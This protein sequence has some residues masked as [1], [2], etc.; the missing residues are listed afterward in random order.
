MNIE[1]HNNVHDFKKVYKE[2]VA[3]LV[4]IRNQAGITQQFMAEW[5]KVD[6]RKIISFENCKKIELE[7]LLKYSDKLSVDVKFNYIIN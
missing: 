2:I 1:V 5:L 3:E 7:I 6:R 4:L